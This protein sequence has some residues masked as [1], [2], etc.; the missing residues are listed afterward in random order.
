M[1]FRMRTGMAYQDFKNL[2][3]DGRTSAGDFSIHRGE[4]REI[5]NSMGYETVQAGGYYW[6]YGLRIRPLDL[7]GHAD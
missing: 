2:I 7:G 1:Q 4:F 5:L 6:I 3:L